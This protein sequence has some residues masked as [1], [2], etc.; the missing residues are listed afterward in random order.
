MI[1][2][3]SLIS[4]SVGHEAEVKN[5]DIMLTHME[6]MMAKHTIVKALI[7]QP[8][9]VRIIV[10]PQHN[11]HDIV[12]FRMEIHRLQERNS[13]NWINVIQ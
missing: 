11:H 7:M 13:I 12:Q 2:M 10:A 9:I 3:H 4:S 8:T 1:H 5:A 6:I